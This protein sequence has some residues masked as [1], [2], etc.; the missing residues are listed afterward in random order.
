MTDYFPRYTA[1]V[2]VVIFRVTYKLEQL[3]DYRWY[4]LEVF[5]FLASILKEDCDCP[6]CRSRVSDL[7]VDAGIL[8]LECDK[9]CE[10]PLTLP[11][12]HGDDIGI[13]TSEN[14]NNE[15]ATLHHES[16]LRND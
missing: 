11:V 14:V 12:A 7:K 5:S 2:E 16:V 6:L 13:V 1:A 15:V 9:L 10:V 3:V 8:S 4:D